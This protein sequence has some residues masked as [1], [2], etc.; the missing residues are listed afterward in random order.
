M[1]TP[2]QIKQMDEISGLNTS[3]PQGRISELRSLKQTPQPKPDLLHKEGNTKGAEKI[4]DFTGGKELSQGLGQAIAQPK[5]NKLTQEAL[6]QSIDIQGKILKLIK[7]K[8]TL[9]QDTNNLESALKGLDD[10]ISTQGEDTESILNPNELTSKEVV[11]DALQLATTAGGAKV[12]GAIA[13]RATQATGVVKGL[14]QG[15]KT[16]VLAGA[17]LGGAT[18]VSQGLQDNKTGEE[19]AKD[20]LKGA[21]IGAVAGGVIGSLTG[22]VSGGV[23]ASKLAKDNQ[24]LKAV[25]PS[26]KDMSADE[27]SEMVR[28]GKISPKTSTNPDKYILS[29]EEIKTATKYKKILSNDPVKNTHNLI[30]EIEKKDKAVGN[31]LRK[32]NGIFNQGE[33]KNSLTSRLQAVDDLTVTDAKLSKVKKETVDSFLKSLKKNDM[34]SLWKARKEFDR[35]IESAFRG[36]PSVTKEIKKEFRNAIQEFI[37]ERTPKGKYSGY[38]KEMR[39]LFELADIT[40]S[41]AN[42]EKGINAI[43]LWIKRNPTKAKTIGW[44]AGTGL[45][46]TVGASILKD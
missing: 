15:A 28:K 6:T 8:K 4:L 3:S 18:G 30:K 1:L 11:G 22:A 24:F 23:K 25:T 37:S 16:G 43:Q 45:V 31:F 46:G 12:A 32:N 27:Y 13:G 2:Q 17:T 10:S 7:E 20:G 35:K 33:L 29:D 42:N 34:E 21:T 38:M 14:V 5:N 19:I 9:G 36:S 41:K 26:T 39:Q 40:D 44:G